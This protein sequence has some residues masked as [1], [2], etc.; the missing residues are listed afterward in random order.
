MDRV[1]DLPCRGPA[2]EMG[3]DPAFQRSCSLRW[4]PYGSRD[5][6]DQG[7]VVRDG[8][9]QGALQASDECARNPI[10]P[11]AGRREATPAS[12]ALLESY[13][14]DRDPLPGDGDVGIG[15][16]FAQF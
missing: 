9:G 15:W 10:E 1:L 4:Q 8:L 2:R 14:L 6:Q 16:I 5:G 13:D 3:P 7:L 12:Y 11:Q